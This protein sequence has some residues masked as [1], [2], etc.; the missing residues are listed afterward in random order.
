MSREGEGFHTFYVDAATVDAAVARCSGF[1]PP[2]TY[3][4][5]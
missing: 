1:E 3:R 4:V 2:G 5:K